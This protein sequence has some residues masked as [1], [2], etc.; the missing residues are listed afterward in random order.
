MAHGS[1]DINHAQYADDTFLLGGASPNISKRFK[2]ELDSYCKALGSKINLRK[3]TIFIVATSIQERCMIFL[4]FLG[5]R[6]LPIGNPLNIL[7][8]QF[9][10]LLKKQ[11]IG[12]LW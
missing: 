4:E 1:K 12:A 10:K 2:F 9:L 6:V 3:K 5:S 11:Q 7:V 8:S